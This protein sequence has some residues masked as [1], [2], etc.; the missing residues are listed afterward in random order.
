MEE[1]KFILSPLRASEFSSAKTRIKCSF[2]VTNEKNS[3]WKKKKKTGS[4]SLM[5]AS[6]RDAVVD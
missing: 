1:L 6:Q 5:D 3:Y 4:L 2:G